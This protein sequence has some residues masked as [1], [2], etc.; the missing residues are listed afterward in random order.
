MNYLANILTGLSLLCGFTSI[1]FS[2]ERHFTFACWAI[3]ISVILDGLDGQIARKNAQP[4][5]FGKEFDSLV[6]VI[7]FGL[8]PSIL[9]Y[10]FIYKSFYFWATLALFIYLL[11]SVTRLAKYNIT[12]SDKM[13][14]YFYGLPT[15]AS[16]GIL[17]S[18][19]L[20]FRSRGLVSLPV[21]VP[22]LF[23]FLILLLAFLMI[24]RIRYLNLDGLKKILGGRTKFTVLTLAILLLAAAAFRRMGISVFLLFLIYLIFSPFVVKRLNDHL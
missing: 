16:G 22:G 19:I 3:I 8:A 4:S 2:L 1:I 13:M 20:I 21:F 9:G 24:S 7:A 18:F 12:P 15:T 17:A 6:D 23:L 11:S 10:I 14:D 5:K